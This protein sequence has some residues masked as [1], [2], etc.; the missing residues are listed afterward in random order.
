[1]VPPQSRGR[2]SATC[3]EAA[4]LP[5]DRKR[6][7]GAAAEAGR[8][9]DLGSG[10]GELEVGEAAEEVL[11]REC[12]LDPGELGAEADVN[13]RAEGDVTVRL[14]ADVQPLGVVED[15]GIAV[16]GCEAG[17]EHPAAADRPAVELGV[18]A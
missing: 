7:E 12:G 15:G 8:E 9:A 11:Q 1:M 18:L 2:H 6:D 5:L 17:K 14:A 3:P 16:G 13:A 10:N 4:V